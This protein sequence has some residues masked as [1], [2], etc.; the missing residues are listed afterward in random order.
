MRKFLLIVLT[1]CIVFDLLVTRSALS[2][3][4]RKAI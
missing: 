1:I 2:L 4:A 3:W